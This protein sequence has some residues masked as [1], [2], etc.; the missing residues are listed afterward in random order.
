MAII[1]FDADSKMNHY[2]K[3]YCLLCWLVRLWRHNSAWL[4][5]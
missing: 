2:C 3:W 5:G 4:S 1:D